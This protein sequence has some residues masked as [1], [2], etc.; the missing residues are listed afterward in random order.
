MRIIV[1]VACHFEKQDK[2]CQTTIT[3]LNAALKYY[4]SLNPQKIRLVVT[5]CVPYEFGDKTLS[6]LMRKYLI[7]KGVPEIFILEG[8][9]FGTFDEARKITA[10]IKSLFPSAILTVISS[11]WYFWSGKNIWMSSALR[12]NIGVEFLPVYGT[13]GIR[14]LA[15]YLCYSLLVKM[16][17]VFKL[18]EPLDKLLTDIYQ[19]RANGFKLNGCA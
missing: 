19:K 3:R 2:L 4:R 13:G 6:T 16:A 15:T 7:A 14:T 1:V 18:L 5:G 17:K 8:K 12:E 10:E 11:N 9:G